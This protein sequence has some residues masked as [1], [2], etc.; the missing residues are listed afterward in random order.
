MT[1]NS[2]TINTFVSQAYYLESYIIDRLTEKQKEHSTNLII[3]SF[4]RILIQLKVIQT[5]RLVF[6]TKMEKYP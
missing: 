2:V 4:C 1:K 3:T 6:T 5:K